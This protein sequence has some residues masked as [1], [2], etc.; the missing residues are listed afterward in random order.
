MKE[1]LKMAERTSKVVGTPYKLGEEKPG[2]GF[3][4]L[5][6]L[7]HMGTKAG[8]EVPTE[9]EGYT[10]ETYKEFWNRDKKG[11]MEVFTRLI[12]SLGEE[13]KPAFAFAGDL[14]IVKSKRTKAI[15]MGLHAGGDKVLTVFEDA[16]VSFADLSM[17]KILRAFRWRK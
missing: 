3:D 8:F 11:A 1:K 4:C 6:L 2:V 15:S 9:F 10:M 13:I 12:A 14:L 7:H 16:G 17:V 5:S